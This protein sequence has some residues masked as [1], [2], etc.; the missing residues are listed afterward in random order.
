MDIFSKIF[1]RKNN[2]LE[3]VEF[4]N[5]VST[6]IEAS[7]TKTSRLNENS[8]N[9]QKAILDPIDI[10]EAILFIVSSQGRNF[11][12]SRGF[13]NILNDFHLLK[14]N[15]AAKNILIGML[16]GGYIKKILD[17][18]NWE[19]DSLSLCQQYAKEFG[20]REDLVSFIINSFGYGLGYSKVKPTILNEPEE[21]KNK[22]V[23]EH[24]STEQE[25]FENTEDYD[26]HRDLENYVYPTPDL[27]ETCPKPT[28]DKTE[29][30]S[31]RDKII[32]ILSSSFSFEISSIRAVYGNSIYYFEI[33]PA[34]GVSSAALKNAEEELTMYLSPKGVRVL[35]PIPGTNKV[36]IEVPRDNPEILNLHSLVSSTEFENS[37]MELPC[38]IGTTTNSRIII[39]DLATLPHLLIGG[40]SG[41]GKSAC[42][43]TIIQ[44]LL[45]K[46]HPSDLK[47]VLVDF[48]RI[49]FAA[50]KAIANHFLATHTDYDNNPIVSN[51]PQAL[52]TFLALLVEIK[53]RYELIA[54]SGTR[55][56]QDYNRKF[57]QRRLNPE[58]GHKYMP[59]IVVIIDE[60]SELVNEYDRS[61]EPMI[62]EIAR[63]GRIAGIH[64]IISTNR[65][66][67]DVINTS[68]KSELT[69]RIAFR[70]NNTTD[71][72]LIINTVGAEKLIGDGDMLFADRYGKIQRIQCA[73]TSTDDIDRICSHIQRQ[74]GYTN[75]Y[76]M[77]DYIPEPVPP[78]DLDHLDPMFDDAARLI[79]YSQS[80]ST[81]TIQRKFAIGY[82]RAGRLMDQLEKAGIVGPARGAKPRDVLIQDNMALENLLSSLR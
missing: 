17:A 21:T 77:T 19:V 70:V 46:K 4:Q 14:D 15:P 22:E 51:I 75:T 82:N 71:S 63:K 61:L 81:S 37:N 64:L 79:V 47:L 6:K 72:R 20:T 18:N 10:P 60:Y 74:R 58:K 78:V 53:A 7:T 29:I 43:H 25:V 68:I 42:I 49:E 31:I 12:T 59:Y 48:K 13:I 57:C 69:G 80:A 44:S 5:P 39:F 11:L 35:A 30:D 2:Y 50:Y 76:E 1:G 55:N 67:A 34:Q 16:D 36:G 65:P 8:A 3:K 33:E 23:P 27:L 73:L 9:E 26:P 32:E 45:F 56:I 40:A 38:L 52:K 66:T 62:L 28:F 24:V 54:A 41:Q